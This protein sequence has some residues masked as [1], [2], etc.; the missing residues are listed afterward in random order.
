MDAGSF[1]AQLGLHTVVPGRV[2][3][4]G[5]HEIDAVVSDFRSR[6]YAVEKSGEGYRVTKADEP[7]IELF[8]R[9][10]AS[11][12]STMRPR[13][14]HDE[15]AATHDEVP[16]SGMDE[17]VSSGKSS[18][19][20]PP[21]RTLDDFL[22][23]APNATELARAKEQVK[24]ESRMS[25]DEQA[26]SIRLGHARSER[27]MLLAIKNGEMPRY[28]A[29]VSLASTHPTFANPNRPFVFATEPADLRGLTGAQAMWQVGWTREWIQGSVNKE[30]EITILDTHVLVETPALPA[31]SQ[32]S[33]AHVDVDRVEWKEIEREALADPNFIDAAEARGVSRE[34]LARLFTRAKGA[35]MLEAVERVGPELAP[36]MQ[37]VIDLMDR[38]WSANRLYTGVGATM[39]EGLKTGA[40]EVMV[41]PNG[42]GLKLT[43]A[44]SRKV[45]LGVM[46]QKDVDTL[47]ANHDEAQ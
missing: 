6:G 22:G 23:D 27:E 11:Q 4:G 18:I 38:L 17:T 41:K 12:T 3:S 5:A 19:Q 45:S 16:P 39:S 8:V 40:R 1:A 47:F 37:I 36:K 9:P 35:T 46:T 25:L 33:L 43:E 31:A 28:I 13:A 34:D 44:N 20:K 30:I 14:S 29:R 21:K 42:T 24:A 7:P 2:F 32:G 26:R 15:G 10:D